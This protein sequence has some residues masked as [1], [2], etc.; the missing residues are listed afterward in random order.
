MLLQPSPHALD[1]NGQLSV[2][3]WVRPSRE[4]GEPQADYGPADHLWVRASFGGRGGEG[5]PA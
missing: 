5:L 4:K 3:M 2:E 1:T